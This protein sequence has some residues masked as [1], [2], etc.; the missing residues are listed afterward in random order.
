[1]R[2]S[3]LPLLIVVLL[4]LAGYAGY[5]LYA[6]EIPCVA[7]LRYELVSYD[8]RFGLPKSE[9]EAD[10]KNAAQ[11]WND[12]LKTSALVESSDPDLPVSFVYD[13]TQ[14]AVDSI[15]NLS[16]NIDTLK[17]QLTQVA[18]EYGDLKKQY[19]SLNARHQAT[20]EMYDNL[21]TLYARY[22]ALRKQ[23]NADVAAGQQIPTGEVEEGKYVSDAA[24]TRIYIYAFQDK[25]ELERTLIHELGHALG[26]EHVKNADSIMYPSNNSSQNTSLTKEDLAELARA[27]DLSK[28]SLEGKA[29]V[30]LLPAYKIVGPYFDEFRARLAK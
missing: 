1:M 8:S 3:S 4:G 26:L 17:A 7:P 13:K 25:T 9:V 30:A 2:F 18:N 12:A 5:M 6:R 11:V 27:C 29:Y 16:N 28:N 14:A 19:D 20:Q 24:G 23:I 10:L 22:E 21:Q 15:E